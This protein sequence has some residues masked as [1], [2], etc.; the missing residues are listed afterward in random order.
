M[1]KTWITDIFY[2]MQG[3]NFIL[4]QYIL[5]GIFKLI[6]ILMIFFKF[7]LI[8]F[9]NFTILYWFCHISTSIRHRWYFKQRFNIKQRLMLKLKLLYFGHQ[10]WRTDLLEKTLM[11]GKTEGRRR[12]GARRMR[13]LDGITDSMDMNFSKLQKLMMNREAWCAAV[14]WIAKSQT[15]LSDWTERN[16]KQSSS[17]NCKFWG[18]QG[19]SILRKNKCS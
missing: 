18:I 1:L 16:I 12:R 7:N 13:W 2:I 5:N 14:H 19:T 9:F 6:R 4:S 17:Y 8:L 11:L 3:D 15:Q 10:M